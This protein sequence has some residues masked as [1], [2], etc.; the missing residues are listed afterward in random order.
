MNKEIHIR[1]KRKRKAL[2]SDKVL[3][4]AEVERIVK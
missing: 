1:R 4:G 3:S 2:K